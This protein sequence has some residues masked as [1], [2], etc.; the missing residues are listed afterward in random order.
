M[1]SS[2]ILSPKNWMI[3]LMSLIQ[4]FSIG[5]TTNGGWFIHL[6]IE[7]NRGRML[8]QSQSLHDFLRHS[9]PEKL[10]VVRPKKI[11]PEQEKRLLAELS[12]IFLKDTFDHIGTIEMSLPNSIVVSLSTKFSTM[13]SI[14][15]PFPYG[16][17]KEKR[18]LL[19]H[20]NTLWPWVLW[21]YYQ[22]LPKIKKALH[23]ER[24]FFNF[25]IKFMTKNLLLF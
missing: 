18:G 4:L 3:L 23:K 15:S 22:Y 17:Q 25:K 11:T 20:A 8:P 7:I 6:F 2:V 5:K 14:L 9:M 10:L 21:D 12:I 1:D 13:T 19:Y 16:V 24:L